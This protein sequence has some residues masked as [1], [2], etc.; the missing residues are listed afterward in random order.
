MKKKIILA[1][2]LLAA[3]FSDV[4]TQLCEIKK[5]G[6]DYL[7]LDVMDGHFVPNISFGTPVVKSLRSASDLQFDVH[8]MIERPERY[9]DDYLSA[10]ADLITFHYEAA[11]DPE[12][13]LRHIRDAHCKAAVSVKPNTPV[14]VL[15][16]LLPF[17]DMVL[18]MTV[19]PGFGG[20]AFMPQML[21]KVRTLAQKREELALSF[22]IEVD[23][24]VGAGNARECVLAGANVL[25]A[26]S[27]VLG[28]SDPCLA[29]TKLLQAALG[30]EI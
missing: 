9:V 20:Q 27:S 23:G 18:I 13:L 19:E 4:G 12:A 5:G 24:G 15:Y 10:G 21:D 17:C 6:A 25:V 14:E 16:G 7:H 3:D 30:K 28:K 29:A 26:G 22:D 1:P 8:L 11:G 2:S